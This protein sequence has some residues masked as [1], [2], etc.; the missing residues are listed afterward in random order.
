MS[1]PIGM[2]A[3]AGPN[4]G[5]LESSHGI[6]S[7]DLVQK[8]FFGSLTPETDRSINDLAGLG[9]VLVRANGYSHL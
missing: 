8:S 1:R 2:F 9:V 7:T 5:E 3:I 4:P 6:L